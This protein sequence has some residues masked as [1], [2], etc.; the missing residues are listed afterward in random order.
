MKKNILH[1]ALLLLLISGCA[2]KDN[3]PQNNPTLTLE[4]PQYY[5][6]EVAQLSVENITLT[7]S[8]YSGTINGNAL[9]FRKCSGKLMFFVPTVA[10]GNYSVKILIAQTEYT[11]A[12]TVIDLPAIADPLVYLQE[13]ITQNDSTTAGITLLADSLDPAIKTAVLNDLQTV[14]TLLTNFYTQYNTLSPAEKEECAKV[15]AANKWW[16]D[17]VHLATTALLTDLAFYKT[18]F[19]VADYEQKVKVSMNLFGNALSKILQHIP[20]VVALAVAGGILGSIVPGL[21]TT[22]G[23]ALG[24]GIGV[25]LMVEDMQTLM[26]CEERFLNTAI[27]TTADIFANKTANAIS[28]T[29]HIARPVIVNMNYRTVYRN[30]ASTSVPI[31]SQ[32]I[33]GM[34]SFQEAFLTVKSFLPSSLRSPKLIGDVPSFTQKNIPVNSYY[35]SASNISNLAVTLENTQ[36]INGNFLLTFQSQ[37]TAQQSFSFKI[38]YNN[39]D[40]GNQSI[41]VDADIM[42]SALELGLLHQG[43]IIFYFLVPGDP[44]YDPNVQHGLAASPVGP[45]GQVEWGCNGSTIS[46]ANGLLLGT[47]NQNT[48][49]IVNGCPPQTLPTAARYC[50]ESTTYAYTDWY[51]PSK[52][53]LYLLYLE[54]NRLSVT[55]AG[56]HWTSSEITDS[57]AWAFDVANVQFIQRDK[58]NASQIYPIRSF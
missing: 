2:K 50:Y 24:A 49:D 18:E 21:G 9:Q 13:A 3:P 23:A 7:D 47:G 56:F 11:V 58:G 12:L 14:N 25:G 53:E 26:A 10:T 8:I 19:N 48:L 44:G 17:E 29:N 46:G 33:N 32:L 27:V 4:K 51:L 55:V 54:R 40:F 1:S 30:D 52:N 16:L 31:A 42:Y 15:L 5:P 37:N 36:S 6:L 34:S 20:K 39:P 43:G 28:F 22:I 38:N 41:T 57:L 45:Y 35:L